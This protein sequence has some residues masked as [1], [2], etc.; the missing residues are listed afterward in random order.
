[1]RDTAGE[2]D[3]DHW[4]AAVV[5]VESFAHARSEMGKLGANVEVAG[6]PELRALMV[7]TA[8]ALSRIYDS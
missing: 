1:V 7:E 8:T 2:T 3:A 5:P 6:P 4:R